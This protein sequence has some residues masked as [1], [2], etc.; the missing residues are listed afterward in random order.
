MS[1]VSTDD[2]LQI[3]QEIKCNISACYIEYLSI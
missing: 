3:P 1:I 2:V